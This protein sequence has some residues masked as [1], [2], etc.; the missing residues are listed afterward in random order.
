[1]SQ[2]TW[3]A[4]PPQPRA[5]GTPGKYDWDEIV[6]AIKDRPG[7]WLLIEKAGNRGLATAI[8]NRKMRA[9]KDP[10]WEFRA[11]VR[12]NEGAQTWAIYISAERIDPNGG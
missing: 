5:S 4:Q 2:Q 12:K 1:M 9:L 11:Q 3:V 10:A 8:R 7:E 6:K